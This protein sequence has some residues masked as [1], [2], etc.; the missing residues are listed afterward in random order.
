MPASRIL[1]Q[2]AALAALAFLIGSA[3][4]LPHLW[5][6]ESSNSLVPIAAE[7][8]LPATEESWITFHLALPEKFSIREQYLNQEVLAALLRHG[9]GQPSSVRS[10]ERRVWRGEVFGDFSIGVSHP[11]L[12]RRLECLRGAV[13]YLLRQTISEDDFRSTRKDEGYRALYGWLSSRD[14]AYRCTACRDR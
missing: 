1:I 13:D 8:W 14:P 7:R 5:Q 9:A 6:V 12:V 10:C 4:A 11:S 2:L 3:A